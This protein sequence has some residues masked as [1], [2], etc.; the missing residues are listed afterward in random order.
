MKTQEIT[1]ARMGNNREA[2]LYLL[3][4][5]DPIMTQEQFDYRYGAE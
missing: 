4:S 1:E 2:A 5:G 3:A